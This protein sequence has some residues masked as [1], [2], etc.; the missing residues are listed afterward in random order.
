MA[1]KLPGKTNLSDAGNFQNAH[2]TAV[3][4]DL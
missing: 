1:A 4:W 3:M 2:E